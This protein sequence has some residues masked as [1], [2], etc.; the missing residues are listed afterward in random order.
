MLTLADITAGIA[1]GRLRPDALAGAV[2]IQVSSVVIDSRQA[3]P[4]SLFV[5]LR[6]EHYDGHDF[7]PAAL[8]AGAVAVI[9][10]RAP[11]SFSGTVIDLERPAPGLPALAAPICLV[12]PSS[13][14]ALQAAA[15]FWRRRHAVRVVGITGS[16]GKT[17]CKELIAAIL[18]RRYHTLRSRGNY[19]NEIGLPLTLLQLDSSH[20][21]VVLEMGMYAMGEISRLAE[22]ALPHVGVVTNVGPSHL[23]RL[24]TLEHI[25]QAKAELP[26][27][28]PSAQEG[29]IAIL[30]ADDERVRAMARLTPARVLTYGLSPE[31]DLW[32]DGIESEGLEGIRFRF[33]FEGEAIHA[34]LPVLGRH[35]VHSALAAAAVALVEGLPWSDVISGLNDQSLQLRIVVV[36]GPAGST[37]VEDV[38]NSSPPSAL[39]ALNLLAELNGRRI[40]VLGDMQELG[41]YA[42]EGH[43]LVGERAREIVDRLV[44]VGPLARIIGEQA[45]EAGMPTSAVQMVETNA[46][47]ITLLLASI[48]PGDMILVKGSRAVKMEEIVAAL[49]RTPSPV[50][51]RAKE[52]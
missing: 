50:Q 2:A 30:N 3:R 35:S 17:T 22:I 48:E 5:A 29:G 21:R 34:H 46:E 32:A 19:N 51:D 49:T 25:A 12:V 24:G 9:T 26:Q 10:E 16:V 6:G 11:A 47:A 36:P 7:I 43:K 42:Q 39:A 37:I 18:S 15:S 38:Y 1:G 52:R 33:H 23:E 31:A 20:E 45:L 41:S 27:A 40:A 44:T 28:L 4:G 13:L 8:A 14:A